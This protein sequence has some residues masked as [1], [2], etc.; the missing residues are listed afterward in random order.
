LA[1]NPSEI[2]EFIFLTFSFNSSH[3]I[4]KREIFSKII[5]VGL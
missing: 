1:G 4:Y 5:G 3:K 2:R